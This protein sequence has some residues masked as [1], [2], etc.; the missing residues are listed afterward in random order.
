L[1]CRPPSTGKGNPKFVLL[2]KVR[3]PGLK[4]FLPKM[5]KDFA[6]KSTPAIRVLDVTE[7]AGAKDA[8]S[9]DQPVILVRPDLV[10]LGENLATLR[11]FNA[12][13]EQ[14]AQAFAST[15]FG[16]RLAQGYEGGATIVAGL[17]VQ[18]ILKK[19]GPKD[20]KDRAMLERTGF[21][22][23]KYLVWDHKSVNGQETRQFDLSFTGY[24]F[25]KRS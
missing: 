10:V 12:R 9:S 25:R 21:S 24:G 4:D 18:T 5:L 1:L 6:D 23:M 22:D 17:D 2:A 11:R 20:E 7:L 19:D 8:P 14:N 16:R 15:D 13:L 3:K